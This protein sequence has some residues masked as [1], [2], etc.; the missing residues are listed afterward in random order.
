VNR[1]TGRG[2]HEYTE[3]LRS[4]RHRISIEKDKL[5]YELQTLWQNSE[6]AASNFAILSISLLVLRL[7]MVLPQ[8]DEIN[9]Q[10]QRDVVLSLVRQSIGPDDLGAA[11]M[12]QEILLLQIARDPTESRTRVVTEMGAYFE[13]HTDFEQRLRSSYGADIPFI[14]AV[15]YLSILTG[16]YSVLEAAPHRYRSSREKDL[17]GR[18]P[19]HIAAESNWTDKVQILLDD[20][21]CSINDVDAFGR[22]SLHIACSNRSTDMVETL[23]RNGAKSTVTNDGWQPLHFA[24][25]N[26]DKSV[27]KLLLASDDVDPN[28]GNNCHLIPLCYAA[29]RGNV[30]IVKLLLAK[31]GIDPDQEDMVGRTALSHAAERGNKAIVMRLLSTGL[32]DAGPL[33][34][35]ARINGHEE[36]TRLLLEYTLHYE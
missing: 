32:V 1:F 18:S 24:I 22:S 16:S 31:D 9:D 25:A 29:K 27:V 35:Y 11:L 5:A 36:I 28:G 6:F 19:L 2:G 21:G 10:P 15:H 33:V 20:W 14:P 30:E 3:C 34:W 17:L 26:E 12:M 13:M 7:Q 4:L 23:L 8:F